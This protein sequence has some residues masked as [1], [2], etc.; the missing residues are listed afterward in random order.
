M[1]GLGVMSDTKLR[2]QFAKRDAWKAA[3]YSA[4][5]VDAATKR[6]R[7]LCQAIGPPFQ[8]A[9]TP[10]VERRVSLHPPKSASE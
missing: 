5:Q 6:C 8:K 1:E 9:T 7:L 10:V 2:R 4:S 3:I